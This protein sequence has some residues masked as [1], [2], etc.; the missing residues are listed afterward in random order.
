MAAARDGPGLAAAEPRP[1]IRAFAAEAHVSL[2]SM[3][4]KRPKAPDHPLLPGEASTVLNV[5]AFLFAS[6]GGLL[7]LILVVGV[8]GKAFGWDAM[9]SIAIDPLAVLVRASVAAGYVWTAWLL[10]R[11]RVL[12]GVLGLVFL[13]LSIVPQLLFGASI[14]RVDLLIA[15]LGAVG[16]ALSWSH[17]GGEPPERTTPVKF[18]PRA[19]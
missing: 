5:V 16:L 8:L 14:A 6:S 1:P 3:P 9:A 2:T 12:G 4:L 18:G 7:L 15:V 10:S 19:G 11:R 17:L 13:G